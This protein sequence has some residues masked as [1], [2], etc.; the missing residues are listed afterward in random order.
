MIDPA[1][2]RSEAAYITIVNSAGRTVKASSSILNLLSFICL[3]LNA[4]LGYWHL[5]CEEKFDTDHLV[6]YKGQVF[7]V[8]VQTTTSG[9]GGACIP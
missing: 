7:W 6:G 8:L 3:I 2:A 9:S 5:N 1:A 4:M